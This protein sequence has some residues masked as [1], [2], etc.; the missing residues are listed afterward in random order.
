MLI[1]IQHLCY[2]IWIITVWSDYL[3]TRRSIQTNVDRTS[4]FLTLC[5]KVN[6]FL[7]YLKNDCF[8]Y[9][10]T[11]KVVF[12]LLKKILISLHLFMKTA[13]ESIAAPPKI[14][15]FKA[16]HWTYTALKRIK[17][18]VLFFIGRRIMSSTDEEIRFYRFCV[19]FISVLLLFFKYNNNLIIFNGSI[20]L[21]EIS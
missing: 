19:L 20:A 1:N 5:L 8:V 4:S 13:T 12:V 18:Y 7:C 21:S 6:R 11:L 15:L 10:R 16:S 17:H 9:I 2:N 3:S 14:W